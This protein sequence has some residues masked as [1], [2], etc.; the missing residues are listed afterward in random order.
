MESEKAV[1][2]L[3]KLGLSEYE[4]RAYT[5]LLVMG[6]LTPQEVSNAANIP[7]TK[8]YEV[9]KRLEAKGWAVAVSRTPMVYAPVKPEVALTNVRQTIETEL[10]SAEKILKAIGK[11]WVGTVPAGVYIIRTLESLKR[12]ARGIVSEAN[13]I[14]L[15]VTTPY[16]IKELEPL[17]LKRKIRGIIEPGL[18]AP[19]YGEWRTVQVFLPLDMLITDC[20]RLLFHFGLLSQHSGPSGVLVM[21]EEVAKTAAKYFDKIWELSSEVPK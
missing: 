3:R 17:I 10:R 7:Y 14:L 18:Q 13:E 16:L 15:T 19:K 5:T 2:A 21:D 9:L 4:A 20:K 11:E 1:D 8:V 6:E 12:I